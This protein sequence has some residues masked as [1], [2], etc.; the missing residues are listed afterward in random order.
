M[1]PFLELPDFIGLCFPMIV[2]SQDHSHFLYGILLFQWSIPAKYGGSA[3]IGMKN[4]HDWGTIRSTSSKQPVIRKV[5]VNVNV[6]W[7]GSYQPKKSEKSVLDLFYFLVY[8]SLIIYLVLFTFF[9][10]FSSSECSQNLY[11]NKWKTISHLHLHFFFSTVLAD[12]YLER[13]A[14]AFIFAL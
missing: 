13:W 9:F 11:A 2:T 3:P 10:F 7:G 6:A 1:F 8:F 12:R 14:P 4:K 5:K